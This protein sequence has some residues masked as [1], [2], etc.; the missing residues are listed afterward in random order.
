MN[1]DTII[2]KVAEYDQEAAYWL[3][4]NKKTLS[5]YTGGEEKN[6]SNLFTWGL[7]PQ[8]YDFWLRLQATIFP[9]CK[10]YY[11]MAINKGLLPLNIKTREYSD[12]GII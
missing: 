3:E 7:S 4:E 10:L 6:L 1:I 11:Q 8:G 2:S 12:P 5:I 9:E